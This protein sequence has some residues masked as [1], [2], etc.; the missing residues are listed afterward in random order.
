M[1][2][3]GVSVFAI[4]TFD[5]DYVLVRETNLGAAVGALKAA[6]HSIDAGG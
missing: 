3:A 4:S 5:T 1:Q 2:K 6:G